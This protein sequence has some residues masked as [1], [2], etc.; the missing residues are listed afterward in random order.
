MSLVADDS[1]ALAETATDNSLSLT[2][3]SEQKLGS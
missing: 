2:S 1:I 3:V